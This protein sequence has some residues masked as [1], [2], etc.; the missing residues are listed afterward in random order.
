VTHDIATIIAN[1]QKEL[2]T[3]RDLALTASITEH[4]EALLQTAKLVEHCTR[5]FDRRS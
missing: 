2:Q 4:R 5:D 1:M 3:I